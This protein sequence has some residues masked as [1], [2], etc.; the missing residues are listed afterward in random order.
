MSVQKGYPCILQL[1][2]LEPLVVTP[3]SNF[4]NVGERC[5]V[6]G[7]KRFLRLVREDRLEEAVEVART[8]VENGAQI[9]D[10]NMD[11]GLLDGKEMM[12]RFLKLIASEP[13]IARVPVM[14]D[15]SK[16]NII[17]AGL[18]CIQGKGIVN[19]ISL[20]EGEKE[21]LRL[22]R[23]IKR[24]GAAVVVM[25]FDEKGQADTFEKRIA[26]CER[27]YR[28]LTEKV[29]YSPCDI[30]LDPNIFPV[31]TGMAE[32]ANYAVD[33]F[34][35]TEWIKEHLP[36]AYVSGG[37]SNVSFAFRGNDR[38]REAMHSVFLYHAI[39]SGM[40]MGIVN[41]ETLT[42][43]EDIPDEL[44]NA[45]EDLLLNRHPD[46]TARLLDLAG[47]LK[48]E[49]RTK[50][51]ESEWR[52]LPVRERLIYSLVHGIDK[53]IER[54]VEEARK[55]LGKGL[56]VVEGPLM[57]GMNKVGDLFGSGQMF[58]PQVVKSARVMKKAFAVLQPYIVKENA[59]NEGTSGGKILLATVNGDVHDIGKNIVSVILSCNNYEI[60]DLGVMVPKEKIIEAAKAHKVDIVG[61][62]GL[63]TPSLHEMEEVAIEMQDKGLDIPLIIGGATTSEKHTA[64][65][66]SPH[67]RAPVVHVKDASQSVSVMEKL[68]G[69]NKA[70]FTGKL[71]ES[72]QRIR[73][74]YNRKSDRLLPIEEA[75]AKRFAPRFET[76]DTPHHTGIRVF[77][78][79]DL[80][81]LSEYIDWTPFFHAWGLKGRYPAIFEKSGKGEQARKLFDDAQDLL[82]RVSAEGILKAGAV[83]GIFPAAQQGDDVVV[84]SPE[85]QRLATLHF[86]RQQKEHSGNSP[87]YS[88]S[89][90]IAP[91]ANGPVDHI[92]LF[93]V[94]AGQGIE[95]YI[96]K[97]A[98][99][100]DDYH[101][102]MIKAL[103]DR[104][105][106]AA[107]EWLHAIVRREF[108]GYAREEHLTNEELIRE[109]YRGIRPAPG[110]P[111]C[112]D[113]TEK[114][115]VF[116]L[117]DAEKHT[118]IRLTSSRA[119]TPAASVSG[120]YFAHPEARYF[121]L[122]PIGEDQLTDYARRKGYN[123][124]DMRKWL[125]PNL[126]N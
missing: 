125:K 6:A 31:G 110:Y 118:G 111:A 36:G 90:F 117:L 63:I 4:V 27:A 121:T 17:E 8:Q 34:R 116:H 14:I 1:S 105:A 26:I 126:Q 60:I 101:I 115:T 106:E 77:E 103:A 100:H 45:V 89:D 41:P 83:A 13:D 40:D 49:K 93:A 80:Q 62:S 44:R 16:W 96:E 7:S 87:Y 52:A 86:L 61:L 69:K 97:F 104:L 9:L 81:M 122:G 75:R 21:F 119:M 82:E 85:G 91:F 43:Y 42:I 64:V 28:L 79:P 124:Q 58:L 108:W 35:A 78:N 46:A 39:K 24:Y 123:L 84:Y 107:A 47:K 20:K 50:T 74:D 66:V 113:H 32:H 55:E 112:P 10:I 18:K 33:Y 56:A 30:I 99:A 70:D 57:D 109:K 12:V 71:A 102:I 98:A 88:L 68:T 67:Y 120:Y 5:N 73:S 2:G 95:H 48:G 3:E 29:G 19:S 65:K 59:V 76:L 94:T 72:Y 23:L 53:H 11:E 15:S 51:A 54:D 22:A 25:A 92:G 37:V 38:I 114:D